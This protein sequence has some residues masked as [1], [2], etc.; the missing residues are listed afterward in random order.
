MGAPKHTPGPW[1]RADYDPYLIEREG[2]PICVVHD[3][4]DFPCWDGPE[5]VL[6]DECEANARL[7]AA[8]PDLLALCKEAEHLMPYIPAENFDGHA[9][10]FFR[11]LAEAIKKVE[12][13]A[14]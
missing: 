5:D 11:R 2:A 10:G 7:V 6:E 1:V 12:G 14:A 8:A 4:S 9:A 13:G 3:A